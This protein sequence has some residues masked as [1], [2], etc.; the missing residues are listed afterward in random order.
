MN[1]YLQETFRSRPNTDTQSDTQ[2]DTQPDQLE[3]Q[4]TNLSA[5]PNTTPIQTQNRTNKKNNGIPIEFQLAI[6]NIIL[7]SIVYYFMVN[8]SFQ[9]NSTTNLTFFKR[10]QS[11]IVYFNNFYDKNRK[12]FIA[13]R[14]LFFVTI[15][16]LPFIYKEYGNFKIFTVDGKNRRV[17]I[18]YLILTIYIIYILFILYNIYISTGLNKKI[19]SI[20]FIS[21]V[22][23][24][25]SLL[26][27]D[28]IAYIKSKDNQKNNKSI[29][30]KFISKNEN[31]SHNYKS[32][33]FLNTSVEI[34]I[35]FVGIYY[36]V[37]KIKI[38]KSI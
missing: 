15:I 35:I 19:P 20:L 24:I 28:F 22:I 26:I 4:L 13:L 31:I 36:L 17:R 32:N 37:S 12:K 16:V 10:F 6:K 14:N 33:Q 27:F 18:N 21:I 38:P 25:F 1:Y 5:P 3:T 11:I 23:F 2:L 30:I 8:L 7:L 29:F 9:D 34:L